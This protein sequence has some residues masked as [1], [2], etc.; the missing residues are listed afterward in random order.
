MSHKAIAIL[1]ITSTILH[2]QLVINPLMFHQ[3]MAMVVATTMSHLRHPIMLNQD[4]DIHIP[5]MVTTAVTA[6]VTSCK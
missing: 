4:M 3:A 5:T 2:H 6:H 1:A